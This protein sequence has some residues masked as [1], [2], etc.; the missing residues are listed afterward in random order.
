MPNWKKAFIM[1]VLFVFLVDNA[2]T[3]W[4]YR[5]V[6][7]GHW[8]AMFGLFLAMLAGSALVLVDLVIKDE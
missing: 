7:L 3:V 5:M 6:G 1:A 8:P 2:H 4:A